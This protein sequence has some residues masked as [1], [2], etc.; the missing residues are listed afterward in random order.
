MSVYIIASLTADPKA[1]KSIEPVL[2][3][4]INKSRLENGC[5]RY[6]AFLGEKSVTFVE[7]WTSVDALNQHEKTIHFQA[8]VI[9]IEKNN[10][11]IEVNFVQS[12]M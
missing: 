6:D 9:E 1:I 5:V 2:K 4:L 7:E 11:G 12:L 10:M 3:E 8:L